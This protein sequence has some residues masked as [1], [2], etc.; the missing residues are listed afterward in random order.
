MVKGLFSSCSEKSEVFV[1]GL[2]G[3]KVLGGECGYVIKGGLL[4]RGVKVLRCYGSKVLGGLAGFEDTSWHRASR[5]CPFF[6][7]VHQR[8][9]KPGS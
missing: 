8:D 1:E 9:E 5:G 7:A 6:S 3:D 4:R 2:Q